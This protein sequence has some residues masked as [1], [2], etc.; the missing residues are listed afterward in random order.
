MVELVALQIELRAAEMTGQPLGEIEGARPPDIML[1]VIVELGLKRR[2][3]ACSGIGRLD[4]EHQRH[5]GF[6]DIAPAIDAEM[7]ALV[8][9]AAKRVRG[10]HLVILPRREEHRTIAVTEKNI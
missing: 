10:L 6:G 9:S 7:A 2:V 8:G 3:C 1:K 4:R 5:Q